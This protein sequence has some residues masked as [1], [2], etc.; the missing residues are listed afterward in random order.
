MLFESIDEWPAASNIG[1]VL[2]LAQLWSL[3]VVLVVCH[4]AI[5]EF[6]GAANH[7]EVCLDPMELAECDDSSDVQQAQVLYSLVA[8]QACMM[9]A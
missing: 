9:K 6:Q 7:G 8:G 5:G 2:V 3:R 1:C 4:E